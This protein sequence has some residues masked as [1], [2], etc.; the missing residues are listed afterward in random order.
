MKSKK[1]WLN[2]NGTKKSEE[3]IK[4]SC[5]DWNSSVWEEYL[6]TIEVNQR[7]VPL[8]PALIEEYS[9]EEHDDFCHSLPTSQEFPFLKKHLFDAVRELTPKQQ[10]V[11]TG[12]FLEELK[13]R[14]VGEMMG[15]SPY[16]VAR[17]R[18]RALKSLGSILIRRVSESARLRTH[19]KRAE[20]VL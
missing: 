7:E 9:Q 1:P 3:A 11:L 17:I 18:D 5:K 4:K 6:K 15:V 8:S 14:E 10:K 12:L 16:A 2:A 13:L 19:K 20:A